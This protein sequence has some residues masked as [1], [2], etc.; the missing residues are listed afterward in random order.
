MPKHTRAPARLQVEEL[1]PRVTPTNDLFA[2]P[3]ADAA[4]GTVQLR[5][6][7]GAGGAAFKN[8]IG[9]YALDDAE[10][11]VNGL[12]PSDAGYIGQALARAQVVF[13]RGA[14]T[15]ARAD[16][17][18]AGGQLLGLFLVSNSTLAE[19][20]AGRAITF[21]TFDAANADRI[22]HVQTRNRGDGGRDFRFEDVLGGGDLDY[23]DAVISVSR[24]RAVATPGQAGQTVQATFTR[25]AGS[26][27]YKN[28]VGLF[29][30][31]ARDGS[32]GGARPGD[33]GYLRAAL[34]SGTRQVIFSDSTDP[35]ATARA[36]NV[37]AGALYGFY[38]VTNGTAETVLANNP[39]NAVGGGPLAYFSFTGANPDGMEHIDWRSETEFGFED[40]PGGGDQDF[41][42]MV[43]RFSFGE[44]TGAPSAPPETDTA[45]PAT[46]F[47]LV[48]DTGASATDRLTNDPRIT[49]TIADPSGVARL[50]AGFDSPATDGFVD[51]ISAF[52]N[53]TLA[54]SAAQLTAINGGTPL[55]DGQRTL[56]LEVADAL[57][58]SDL[59]Q[60]A[61]RLDRSAPGEPLFD[62]APLSDSGPTG[63]LRT[64]QSSVTL[65]GLAEAGA[66]LQ[67][68]RATVPGTPGT[69]TPVATATAA[70]NGTFAFSGVA[71]NPGANSFVVRVVDAA[72]NVGGTLAQTFTLNAAPTVANPIAPQALTAGDPA[73]TF[74]LASV[75]AD[76]EQVVRLAVNFLTGQTRTV[77]VNVFADQAPNSVANFLAY[78]TSA[79]PTQSYDNTVFHRLVT[80]F[81]LQGG[82]F[83]FNDAGTDTA[84]TFPALTKLPPVANEPGISNTRGT[85]A[86]A[87]GGDP[88]S[89]T[90]EFFFNLEDNSGSLDSAGNAGGFSVF[91]QV[92]NG[93]QQTIDALALLSTFGGPGLPGAPPFPVRTG[94]NTA[95]FPA[96]VSAGDVALVTTARVLTAAE[97][98]TFQV[99]ANTNEAVATA[100]A[101][102]PTLSVTP[103]A[104]GT[105][106]ITVEARDLD[107][108]V[109]TLQVAVTVTP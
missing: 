90:S 100:T 36:L 27:G 76:A 22:D 68:T 80:A 70:S 16:L 24:T 97:R 45:P 10:G 85:I 26:A 82:G 72:G 12:L 108:S 39:A 87:K 63:D 14:G 21:F 67:L 2:V 9:V 65:T 91:G 104:A 30:V 11:R 96:N 46:A 81:V 48:A 23:N 5:F 29:R 103:L 78:V 93:G 61:F 13:A 50:R 64:D 4:D 47:A 69:G 101:T 28:E 58:N 77:D 32:I 37:E 31:D 52:S 99:L 49:V 40:L 41:D 25:L 6:E 106:T 71:L 109:R 62:L 86:F 79:D 38:F 89:A 33:P 94:T 15:G 19:A 66:T 54:L 105:T 60:F 88:N 17:T 51:V 18:V 102:G 57:G 44:P 34:A 98:M 43:L 75:F 35:S 20:R 95:N 74:D 7:W 1:E 3:A 8:E 73:A 107:G 42:D 84:T 59:R 92:M 55:A 53:G 83:K 56:F